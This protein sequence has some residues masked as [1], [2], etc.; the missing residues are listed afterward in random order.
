MYDMFM[1][2]NIPQEYIYNPSVLPV[3]NSYDRDITQLDT[4]NVD[5]ICMEPYI[6]NLCKTVLG[7]SYT[8]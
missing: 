1:N 3:L 5:Y 2:G 4:D 8:K 6:D 7:D